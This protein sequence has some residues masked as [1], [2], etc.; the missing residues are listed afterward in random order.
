MVKI[1]PVKPQ[2]GVASQPGRVLV[3]VSTIRG[4]SIE[5]IHQPPEI[6]N[7]VTVDV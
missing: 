2:L 1:D 5:A 7:A 6:T 3:D 4:R